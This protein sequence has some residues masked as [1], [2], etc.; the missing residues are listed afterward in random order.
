MGKACFDY[1]TLFVLSRPQAIAC[2]RH[3]VQSFS[4]RGWLAK[5]LKNVHMDDY[6][7]FIDDLRH[8]Y[9]DNVISGPVVDDMD[10]FPANC[11]ELARREYTLHVFKLCSLGLGHICPVLSAMGLSYSMSEVESVEF[12][13]VI[14]PL[15]SY[16]LCGEMAKIFSMDPESI[17]RCVELVDNFGDEAFRA[18]YNPWVSVDF[19]G[20]AGIVEGLSKAYKAVRVASDVDTSSMSTVLQSPGKLAMQSRTPVQTPKIDLGKTSRAG[21]ASA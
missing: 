8:L 18:E 19:P 11:P 10:T 21:T 7:E 15:Q 1:P 14:E 13:S 6:V 16:L 3:L 20:R 4:S 2:Y 9:L 5:E 12:S 17:A